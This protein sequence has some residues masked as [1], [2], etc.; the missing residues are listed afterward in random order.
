MNFKKVTIFL[1]FSVYI[2]SFSEAKLIKVSAK[3]N[4]TKNLKEEIYHYKTL[5]HLDSETD[6]ERNFVLKVEKRK[7]SIIE[8]LFSET[9]IKDNKLKNIEAKDKKV[10][11]NKTKEIKV[12]DKK[13]DKLEKQGKIKEKDLVKNQKQ[14]EKDK[15]LDEAKKKEESI[16]KLYQLR[17]DYSS[18]GK[19]QKVTEK[20]YLINLNGD[21]IVMYIPIKTIK[22]KY[23]YYS[24]KEKLKDKNK[25]DKTGFVTIEKSYNK[26]F[27][28]SEGNKESKLEKTISQIIPE[29]RIDQY[30]TLDL[31]TLKDVI[32]K[33]N[34]EELFLKGKLEF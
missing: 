7:D 15:K 20:S 10:K 26:I 8:T 2:S 27:Y 14:Q 28:G 34:T 5:S 32:K 29:S 16:R 3:V 11:E 22:T 4:Q 13:L 31:G 30:N 12:E 24:K 1:M 25:Q 21:D 18:D 9:K 33:N 17:A 6:E 19:I 23:E